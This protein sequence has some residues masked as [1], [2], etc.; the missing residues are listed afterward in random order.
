MNMTFTTSFKFTVKRVV[1]SGNRQLS[2]Y[3]QKRNKLFDFIWIKTPL[4][5]P[6]DVSLKL[7]RPLHFISHARR[8]LIISSMFVYPFAATFPDSMSRAALMHLRAF[9]VG[10]GHAGGLTFGDA[11]TSATETNIELT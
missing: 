1:F 6:L 9:A 7:M 8:S 2:I 10:S 3:A 4:N 5:C 11:G